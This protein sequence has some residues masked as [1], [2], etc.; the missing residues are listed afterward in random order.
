M[1]DKSLYKKKIIDHYKNPRNEGKIDD[2]THKHHLANT[3]C[4]DEFTVYLKIEGD[5]IVDIGYEGSGCAVSFAGISMLSEKIRGLG[6]EE[7]LKQGD[8]YM[9][10]M[11]GMKGKSPRVKCATVGLEAVKRAINM[12]EEE[13]CDFC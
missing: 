7:I 9:L 8:D 1:P 12:A 3:V 2:F 4:G 13:E 10:D 6:V 11:L 5:K